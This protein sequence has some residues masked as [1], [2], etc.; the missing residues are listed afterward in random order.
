[1]CA[2]W[3]FVVLLLLSGASAWPVIRPW[4]NGY[5]GYDGTLLRNNDTNRTSR[6]LN[7]FPIPVSVE[8]PSDDGR[9]TGVCLNVYECR[10]Q[11]GRANG[12]CALGFGVCCVFTATCGA[13]IVNNMTYFVS[14]AFPALSR[15]A[16]VCNVQIQKVAPS[17]SQLRLDFVHFNLGQPNRRTGVC[18]SDVFV[19]SGGVTQNL[20]LCGQNSGQHVYYDVENVKD[21]INIVINL[22]HNNLFRMWEI[23]II[24]I[25]FTERAPAGCRQY[26]QGSSGIIQTMNFADNGRHLADQDYN[27]CMRQEEGMCSIAYEPCDENSFKIGPPVLSDPGSGDGGIGDSR[28]CDDK[29]VMPCDSEEFLMPE[30]SGPGVCDLLHCGSSF[31]NQGEKPCRIESSSTP[32]NIRV[33]FGPGIREESPED[34]IGMCLHYEQL[35]CYV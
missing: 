20:K 14:P 23:K 3:H 10:M 4:S 24:Q 18:E 19:M 25:E 7:F 17:V 30:S 26:H 12:P 35:P 21:P 5:F 33:Q 16:A 29:I 15:D 22:T 28:D 13:D 2:P 27:I 11:G 1:M 9:R 34:N 6:V 32:F 31:C 8:C